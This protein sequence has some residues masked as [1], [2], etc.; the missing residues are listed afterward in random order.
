MAGEKSAAYN[1]GPADLSTLQLS[2]FVLIRKRGQQIAMTSERSGC[3]A[4][5]GGSE[6]WKK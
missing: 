6:K 5:A 2:Y 3:K 1:F 4:P